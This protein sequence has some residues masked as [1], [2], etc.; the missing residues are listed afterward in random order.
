[1]SIATLIAGKNAITFKSYGH[2]IAGLLFTPEDFDPAKK[3]PT[4]LFNDPGLS[5]KEMMGSIYGQK[6][7][8]RG[9]VY[10]CYDRMGLGESEG[11]KHKIKVDQ[12]VEVTRDAISY[13]RTLPFVDRDRLY[14]A[15]CC[16]GSISMVTTAFTDK[17]LAAVA[18][19]SALLEVMGV[20]YSMMDR[21]AVIQM[22]KS[23]NEARQ[24]E[25]ETGEVVLY[26][27]MPFRDEGEPFPEGTPQDV[28]EGYDY[29]K[30]ARCG[31]GT[32]YNSMVNVTFTEDTFYSGFERY[33]E[34]FYTP[35]LGIVG[36]KSNNYHLTD[37]FYQNCSEPK[38][39]LVVEGSSHVDLYDGG[40][41]GDK[42]LDLAADKMDE[43]FKKYR[44]S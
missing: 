16:A 35:Y 11:P 34:Y 30:T 22:Y 14:G 15:G 31:L 26:D 6:M 13:L 29:Y 17:R 43:F 25:Y 2:N 5:V 37:E 24:Q 40:Q 10:L 19:V 44:N 4:I 42:Y 21:E 9:Y 39:L 27:N 33:A 23:A 7:A 3:Y 18:T 12:A 8:E 20:A 32:N 1:M 38:E 36:E 41:Y 28:I